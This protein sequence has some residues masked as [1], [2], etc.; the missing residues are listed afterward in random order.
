MLHTVMQLSKT[1]PDHLVLDLLP[2]AQPLL[3]QNWGD[4]AKD[5]SQRSTSSASSRQ[6]PEPVPPR[7]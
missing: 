2:A 4:T 1:V 5:F 7:A 3:D 6:I